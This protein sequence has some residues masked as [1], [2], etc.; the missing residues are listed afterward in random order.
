MRLSVLS[1]TLFAALATAAPPSPPSSQPSDGYAWTPTLAGYYEK[2]AQHIAEA[3]K[4]PGFPAPPSCDLSK[5]TLPVAPTPLPSP[6]G[7]KLAHVAVGRGVQVS[8]RLITHL[9]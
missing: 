4:Q 1:F 6:D 9:F 5:A 8:Q 2:V 7:L 3:R